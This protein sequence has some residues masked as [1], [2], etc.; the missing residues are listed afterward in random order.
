MHERPR[1]YV[2]AHPFQ[3]WAISL[4]GLLACGHVLAGGRLLALPLKPVAPPAP[5]FTVTD[6]GTL[7][8]GQ[9]SAA[10]ALNDRGQ[11]VGW[12]DSGADSAALFGKDMV[13]NHAVLWDGGKVRDL[14]L[15]KG[16][17]FSAGHGINRSGQIVGGWDVNY[18][19]GGGGPAGLTQNFVLRGGRKT[20][21]DNVTPPYLVYAKAINDSGQVAGTTNDSGMVPG[22]PPSDYRAVLWMGS[23]VTTLPLPAGFT[24]TYANALNNTGMV[25]GTAI[26]ENGHRHAVLW[27]KGGVVD[28][29]TVPPDIYYCEATG[30]NDLGQA[31][32]FG[33]GQALLWQNGKR[34]ELAPLSRDYPDMV[35]LGINNLGQIVGVADKGLP[36]HAFLWQNGTTYDLNGLIPADAGWILQEARAI[37]SHGQIV[38]WGRHGGKKRAFLLTPAS[39]LR[40]R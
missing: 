33:G 12:S 13:H 34:E 24:E 9:E 11:V 18:H 21:L 19:R 20:V 23:K 32:G 6:L 26:R 16:V 5:R 36:R 3:R 17:P 31:I 35:A 38:G 40:S 29:C 8:S 25:V 10:Y 15:L 1:Q 2:Q 14:G 7:P 22:A 30:V 27:R 39:R 28:L 4:L 37:N